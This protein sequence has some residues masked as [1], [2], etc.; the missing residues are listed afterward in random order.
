MD[1]KLYWSEK[2]KKY[3]TQDWITKPT[4]FAKFAINYFQKEGN[5]LDL[6]AGQG[7]DSRFFTEK[8][9]DVTATEYSETAIDL[10]KLIEPEL[11]IKYLVHD[12]ND[13]LHFDDE[14]FDIVYSHLS[15][16]F[17]NNETTERIFNEISRVLKNNGI[18]AIMVNSK[19]DPEVDL[20]KQISE[21]LYETPNGLI[22]RFY[23]E[24]S[25]SK[26]TSGKFETIILDSNGATYKDEI[27]T[28]IRFI[29]RK[30]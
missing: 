5:L 10:A 28:L 21:D 23:S 11:N 29:G 12:L 2:H 13:K 17:F 24:E 27:K 16:Q 19:T 6:G 3:S 20:S 30:L 4:I 9:Y 26:F 15:I 1:N 22:K 7:Q 18:I 14:T 25:L 8:G